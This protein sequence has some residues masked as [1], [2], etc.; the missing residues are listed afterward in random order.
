MGQLSPQWP[1]RKSTPW[2]TEL[3][4]SL[5]A[6]VAQTNTNSAKLEATGENAIATS[7]DVVEAVE[8][9]EETLAPVA[10]SGSYTDLTG[11]PTVQI[12]IDTDGTPYLIF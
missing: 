12:G 7:A 11:K 2:D 4:A 1:A 5:D 6:I 3:N 10:T 9:L 8:T